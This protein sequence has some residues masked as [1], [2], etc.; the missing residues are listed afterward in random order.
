MSKAVVYNKSK[1]YL[2]PLLS[3]LIEFDVRFIDNLENTY[4]YADADEYENH[5]FVLH[6]YAFENPE[7]TAYESKLMNNELYVDSI[8]IGNKVLFIFKFPEEYLHEYHC[9]EQGRYSAFGV[10]TKELIL[11]FWNS[12][13]SK[14]V[15][16][17]PI[18]LKIKQI[19][20]KDKKLKVQLEKELST[21]R[22]PVIIDDDAELG[23][24]ID[25][26]NETF[27]LKKHL[28]K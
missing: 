10:D 12:I 3:E 26:N 27:E 2:L 25:K 9:L 28:K 22:A 4:M 11:K 17:T 21:P 8:D 16:A 15:S 24:A 18:L 7:F 20:F 1:T 23:A 19:L 13:Y 14:F 5:L 6:Q